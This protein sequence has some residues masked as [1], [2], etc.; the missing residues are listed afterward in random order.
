VV[1]LR[2]W[3]TQEKGW[4]LLKS[5]TPEACYVAKR[6]K[7][8]TGALSMGDGPAVKKKKKKKGRGGGMKPNG[9]NRGVGKGSCWAKAGLLQGMKRTGRAPVR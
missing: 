8:R 1:G 9:R 7:K 2:S 5:R 3:R 6:D 4:V